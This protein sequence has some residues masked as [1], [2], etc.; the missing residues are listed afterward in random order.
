LGGL[1]V[2]G[3]AAGVSSKGT[4]TVGVAVDVSVTRGF[5]VGVA[6]GVSTTGPAVDAGPGRAVVGSGGTDPHR[7]TTAVSGTTA[8]SRRIAIPQVVSLP[9]IV[10]FLAKSASYALRHRLFP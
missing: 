10:C 3:V 5:K 6:V 4:S 1:T 7:L 9:F 8:V 2:V